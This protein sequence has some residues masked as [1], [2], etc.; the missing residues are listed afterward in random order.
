[1]QA[2]CTI[3]ILQ[4]TTTSQQSHLFLLLKKKNKKLRGLFF[5]LE[6]LEE[7]NAVAS[8]HR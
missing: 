4:L 8:I 2:E 7:L 1:M 3:I 5:N 6:S